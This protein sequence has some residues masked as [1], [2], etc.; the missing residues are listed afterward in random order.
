MI[1]IAICDDDNNF[2]N[3][4][5]NYIHRINNVLNIDVKISLFLSGIDLLDR[6][7]DGES[8]DIIFMDIC[9]PD[10]NGANVGMKIKSKLDTIIVYMSVSD[11]YFVDIFEVKPL[12]F[13]IK[14]IEFDEFER[15]FSVIYNHIF[16]SST[17]FEFKTDRE[18]IRIK[19]KDIIYF[20]NLGRQVIVFTTNG[21]YKFYEKLKNIYELSKN[22]N[23]MFIHKSYI[24]NY[25]HISRI[26]YDYVE[27]TN[28][29]KLSISERRKKDIR[30]LYVWISEKSDFKF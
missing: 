10:M 6:L 27:M 2:V 16:D 13:L 1:K 8:F 3:T 4:I 22:Y 30:R 5:E 7:D 19:F 17:F 12:G 18:N 11:Q 28:G 25:D 14:P 26:T 21:V 24:I 29:E 15:I 23:F 9:M 20:K